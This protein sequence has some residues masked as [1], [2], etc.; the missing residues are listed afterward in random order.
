MKVTPL[1]I[2]QK[3]FHVAFRGYERT[4]VDAFLDT[5]REEMEDLVREV[6]ELR[7]FHDSYDERMREFRD[8]EETLKSTLL[9]THKLAEDIKVNSRKEADL[10]VKDA[11][12]KFHQTL[13][14][15]RQEKLKLDAEIIELRRKKH[16]FLQDL[17]KMLQMHMEMVSFEGSAGEGEAGPAAG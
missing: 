12:L 2:Q 1:D 10:I 16:H 11:E 9:T 3:R 5:V 13:E 8:R 7:E 17:R 6:T 14:Q 4:E 15:A